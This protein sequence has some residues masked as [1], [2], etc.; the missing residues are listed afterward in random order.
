MADISKITLPSGTTYDIKD[1]TARSDIS[2]LNSSAIKT[3]KVNGTAL[4]VTSNAVDV[5]VPEVTDTYD[6]SSSDAMSGIAV[7]SAIA[8]AEVGS[9]AFQGIVNSGSAISGL[10]NYSKGWYWVVGTAGTYVGQACE[11]GDFIFCIRNKSGSYLASDFSVVQANIDL[12]IFGEL[13]YKDSATG[14][15]TPAG[16]VALTNST[17]A[18]TVSAAASGSATYTPAGSV[19]APTISVSTAGA[20]ASINNP[21]SVTVAKTVTAAAPGAT[22]PDN[23]ITY[24]SVSNETLSLYQL[25]YTTGDSI[26]TSNVTVKTGDAAYSASAPTFTGTGARLVTED[27]SIPTSANFTGTSGNVTVS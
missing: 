3:V 23:N 25:G 26:T 13:A 11:K 27:I 19:S 18:A 14:T 12:S 16:N 21:S 17:Q 5:Q 10:D 4:P 7:A 15:F 22:A 20:T 2:T 8:A 24:Y 6:A 9:A 1:S